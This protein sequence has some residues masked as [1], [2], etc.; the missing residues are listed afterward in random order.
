MWRTKILKAKEFHKFMQ[1]DHLWKMHKQRDII[2]LLKSA[3]DDILSK[4]L[5]LRKVCA[6]WVPNF[7]IIE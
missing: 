6:R 5:D 4:S 1:D 3:L 7:P 2:G